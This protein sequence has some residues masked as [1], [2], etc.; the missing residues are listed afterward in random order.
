MACGGMVRFWGAM[1]T[2]FRGYDGGAVVLRGSTGCGVL[3]NFL[4]ISGFFSEY[5]RG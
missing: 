5:F 4:R 2:V 3:G 1:E